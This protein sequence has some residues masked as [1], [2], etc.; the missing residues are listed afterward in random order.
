MGVDADRFNPDPVTC[1]EEF[2]FNQEDVRPMK[3]TDELTFKKPQ[4]WNVSC[5]LRFINAVSNDDTFHGLI[6]QSEYD[7]E[8]ENTD[9]N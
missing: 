5:D 6:P 1:F 7:K 4:W 2:K 3:T 9:E 8:Q